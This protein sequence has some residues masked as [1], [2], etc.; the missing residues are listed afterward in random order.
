MWST[1][2]HWL[3]W[4]L[5]YFRLAM[6]HGDIW[7]HFK[8]GVPKLSTWRRPGHSRTTDTYIS[9]HVSVITR[10]QIP[11][12]KS[13]SLSLLVKDD[14]S[15]IKCW[16]QFW[17]LNLDSRLSF[18][19]REYANILT[20]SDFIHNSIIHDLRQTQLTKILVPP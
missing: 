9:C 16:K 19:N 15:H 10:Q 6:T 4:S 12:T 14:K 11:G 2:R 13:L 1:P 20:K 18:S 3:M 17:N 7:R 8:L 5:A